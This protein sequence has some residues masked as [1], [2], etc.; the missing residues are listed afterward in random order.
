MQVASEQ[1]PGLNRQQ[2]RLF[3]MNLRAARLQLQATPAE[4]AAYAHITPER[5][6]ALEQDHDEP[7]SEEARLL[8]EAVGKRIKDMCDAPLGQF[9]IDQIIATQR[10]FDDMMK[11]ISTD[12]AE[13][14]PIGGGAKKKKPRGRPTDLTPAESTRVVEQLRLFL[15]HRGW[16]KQQLAI[17]LG[18]DPGQI[19]KVLNGI[20]PVGNSLLPL[21]ANIMGVDPKA[22][23]SGARIEFA[24]AAADAPAR[25]LL[26]ARTTTP[27]ARTQAGRAQAASSLKP[28]A[29]RAPRKKTPRKH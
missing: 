17:E 26:A 16:N 12:G 28:A 20:N 18:R 5:L 15:R 7:T 24:P 29:A 9:D 4:L 27:A 23:R 14:T 19:N 10:R 8:S 2:R 3:S 13:I 11:R 6:T 25:E 22:L 1:M 21:I